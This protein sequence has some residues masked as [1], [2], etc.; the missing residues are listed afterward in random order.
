LTLPGRKSPVAASRAYSCARSRS[1]SGRDGSVIGVH[2]IWKS[3]HFQTKRTACSFPGSLHSCRTPL[4]E[5]IARDTLG[6]RAA[7][8]RALERALDLAEPDGALSL[9]LLHLA[10]GPPQHHAR[11]GT[12]HASLIAKIQ[13]LLAGN[14]SPAPSTAGWPECQTWKSSAP[15]SVWTVQEPPARKLAA[16]A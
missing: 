15:G 16:V 4:L 11:H 5:A 10:P 2:P 12:A 7:A 3:I 13:T 9:F 1:R 14:K 8:G 6:D